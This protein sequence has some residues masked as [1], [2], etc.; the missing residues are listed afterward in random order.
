MREAMAGDFFAA[1]S[2][3]SPDKLMSYRAACIACQLVSIGT[4]TGPFTMSMLGKLKGRDFSI[5]LRAQTDL[6]QMGEAPQPDE[7][8]S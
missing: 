8:T 1:E 4:F 7:A 6:D 5:L 3:A 2:D